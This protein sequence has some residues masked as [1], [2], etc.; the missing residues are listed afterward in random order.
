MD[1]LQML[2]LTIGLITT[3][4][5]FMSKKSII[6][7]IHWAIGGT[8]LY[9]YN[10]DIEELNLKVKNLEIKYNE[11]NK[12]LDEYINILKFNRATNSMHYKQIIS[13]I[14]EYKKNTT[15]DI[16]EVKKELIRI[17]SYLWELI[18]KRGGGDL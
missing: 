9:K 8:P 1:K 18:N 14:K 2:A 13:N 5:V 6:D 10:E 4:A 17:N 11:I 16:I 15:D 12:I 7:F 3:I